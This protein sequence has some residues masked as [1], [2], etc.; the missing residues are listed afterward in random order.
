[1]GK[2]ISQLCTD[3]DHYYR[4]M[5]VAIVHRYIRHVTIIGKAPEHDNSP[6]QPC[7]TSPLTPPPLHQSPL[8]LPRVKDKDEMYL[9]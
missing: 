2:Y 1:M 5:S 3:I 7:A 9:S 8:T 4:E 6:S